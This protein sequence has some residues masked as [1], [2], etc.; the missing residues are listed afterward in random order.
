MQ[1][2]IVKKNYL[3]SEIKCEN[4]VKK[5]YAATENF[6]QWSGNY[7]IVPNIDRKMHPS[8]DRNKFY[9]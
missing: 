7:E 5:K 1:N 4:I 6:F 9:Q 8:P 3:K 2:N